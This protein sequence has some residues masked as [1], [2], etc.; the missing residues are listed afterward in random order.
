MP[1]KG[2]Q[3]S[4][5]FLKFTYLAEEDRGKDKNIFIQ[6]FHTGRP[7]GDDKYLEEL[8]AIT[9]KTYEEKNTR[10]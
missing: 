5:S 2:R 3:L 4:E 8:E 6:H 7:L 1:R 9:G 10:A